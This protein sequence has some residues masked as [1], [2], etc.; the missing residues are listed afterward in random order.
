MLDGLEVARL[1]PQ[2]ISHYRIIERIGAGGMGEVFL[3]QDILLDRRVAIKML[4]SRSI[5]SEQSKKRLFR[6][7]KAAATLDHPN[8]CAIYEVGEEGDCAFIAMQYIEGRTLSRVIKD[9]PL[10]PSDVV[11]IGIQAAEALV[12]AHAHGVIHRDIKPQNAILTP[13]GQLKI[14]D[15][16]LAKIL[17]NEP[18]VHT[19]AETVSRL[20]ESG[21]VVGT[22]GYMSPEQLRDLPVDT[23]SDL[24]SLGV[25]LYECA[26]G[27][28][29][30]VGS[31]KIE[32]CMQVIQVDPPRPS[33]LDSGIP[34]GLDE[35]IA[36]AMA[37]EVGDRYQSAQAML[38]DLRALRATLKESSLNTRPFTLNPLTPQR[39][40]VTSAPGSNL[41]AAIRGVPARYKLAAVLIPLVI[42]GV[43]L[44]F[45]GWRPSLHQPSAK[46]QVWYDRGV[47][48]MRA[49]TY[50][51]ASKALEQSIEI[52]DRF[53]LAHA[54]L[55]DTY[56]E[57]DN[58]ERAMEEL[59]QALSLV[60]DRGALANADLIY[61]NAVAATI[62]RDLD[63]AIGH[64]RELVDET[65]DADKANAYVDLGRSYE[66]REHLGQAIE[67]YLE[68]TKRDTQSAA[69][70]L[71]LAILYGRRQD[72][73][74]AE[75]AFGQAEK[76]YRAMTNQEGLAELFYQRGALLAKAGKISEAK[77]Q[78]ETALE[79]LKSGDNKYQLVKTQLQLS[80]VYHIQG[81][82]EHAKELATNAIALAQAG[83]IRSLA[84]NGLID[85]GYTLLNRGEFA[86]SRT[87][88]K[89]ALD[90]AQ[91]DKMARSEARALL[92]L[93]SLNQQQGN[94][95]EAISALN[96]ALK[97]YEPGGYR[98]E[99]S[100]AL[101]LLGRAHQARGESEVAFKTF[102][103]QLEIARG[104]G[105]PAQ[106]S[107]T[108]SSIALLL[109]IDEERY[110]EALTKLDEAYKIDEM[111]GSKASMGF[112]QMN[113]AIFLGRLG[114][115]EEARSALDSALSISTQAGYK[116]LLAWVHLSRAQIALS[117]RQFGEAK[118]AG[119]EA[120]D[121]SATQYRKVALQAKYTIG[122]ADVF[123][124]A[125]QTGIKACEQAVSI[126]REVNAPQLISTSLLS[127]SE[128]LVQ[129]NDA[130][131]A[132]EIASQTQ[133]IF[134]RSGQQDSEWR[135]V[136]IAA[137]ASSLAG[138]KSA[139][140]DYASR[141]DKLCSGLEQ[142]WGKES[143]NT[144]LSRPDIQNYRKQLAQILVRSN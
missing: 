55:A 10:S 79:T 112:G 129:G 67:S 76:I 111:R 26:T 141:A 16:G 41:S 11:D 105:D 120:L 87:Y 89:Q 85:L 92:A 110:P 59:L 18:S 84:T 140:R 100:I 137:Q 103:Q 143:Y 57:I 71:R 86:E 95:D 109:G 48:A 43:F 138:N 114:R 115:Y 5:G 104:L 126:A 61:V 1:V 40:L 74:N 124:G 33:A 91:R 27:K 102:E 47:N 96:A 38:E 29:A 130:K 94:S 69:A 134:A 107:A 101:L 98:K 118:K 135:A 81:N 30:F 13:R 42:L 88:F 22:V 93:G 97:F 53:A 133:T 34:T 139:A 14:L 66:K 51:Q 73:K 8:I 7:A 58:T 35:I 108:L 68:A 119:Q 132:V 4:P 65:S 80:S 24:F 136:L 39:G 75:D 70:F 54:R 12:E 9:N 99:I 127:L 44:A 144:Y 63:A 25:M 28:S 116:E 36:K 142:K 15:F 3:A 123:S 31:S 2:E 49:G 17:Q 50:Y 77:A 21:D 128:A 121:L 82:T 78:L 62:R 125:T 20:T 37:K 6:E 60:P 52:D 113:R 64:Y 90:W 23:R 72:W 56:N 122:L 46:A 32:I 117:T 106:V 45:R 19:G 131:R 83:N